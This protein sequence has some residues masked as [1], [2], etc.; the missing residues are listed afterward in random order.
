MV[1][2]PP[3]SQ[4]EVWRARARTFASEEIEPRVPEMERTDRLPPE[5]L[6]RLAEVGF[7]GLTLPVEFG[8]AGASTRATAAVL[9]EVA[10]ASA[11]VATLL[12]VHL[13]VASTPLV[14]WGTP[15]QKHR[16]LPAMAS[17]RRL[18]AFALTESGAGSDAGSIACRY[19][20]TEGGFRLDGTKMFIT[21][22]ALADLLITFANVDP[23]RGARGVS[24]FLVEKGAPGL[25]VA[26]RLAKLGLRGSET[27][28]LVFDGLALPAEALL[29]TE[30]QGLSIALRALTDGRVG[31]AAVALGVAEAS[32]Q[33]L[34][35]TVRESRTEGG[36]AAVARAFTEVSAA[37][38]LVERA[39][40]LRD[41]GAPFAEAAS[42][43]KLFASEVAVR[44]AESAVDAAGPAGGLVD[45]R[46]GRLLR[47]ARVFPIVEGTSE[48][49]E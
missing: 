25:S 11:A 13:S 3:S 33:E 19:R 28:E 4:V 18:G 45:G 29:G 27:T 7:L 40:E 31:I 14:A 42:A 1:G 15:E 36:R 43:A 23:A 2:T 44:T 26:Q 32:L 20:R 46:A 38:A 47:D 34:L 16:Y 10:R 35:E 21:N 12:S 17:G 48:V 24:A 8:G 30:G 22:G 49:Q 5:I 6:A 39:A 41:A 9:G 37:R